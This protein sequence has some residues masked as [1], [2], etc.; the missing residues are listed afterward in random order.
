[1]ADTVKVEPTPIQRNKHDVAL[2][3]LAMHSDKKRMEASEIEELYAKYYAL[4]L[5]LERSSVTKLQSLLSDELKL[6]TG[7]HKDVDLS[8]VNF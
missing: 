1:M 4:A 8:N 7:E 5:Y 2:E 3:L 6:K